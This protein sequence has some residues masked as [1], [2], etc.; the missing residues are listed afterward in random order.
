MLILSVVTIPMAEKGV[1]RV[2]E[3]LL[4]M[5]MK[6]EEIALAA[7][8]SVEKVIEIKNKYQHQSN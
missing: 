1:L 6:V 7:E 5:G 4:K 8:I 2:V 3:N